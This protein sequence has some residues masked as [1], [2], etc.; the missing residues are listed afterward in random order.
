MVC[1]RAN[2]V[3]RI[4]HLSSKGAQHILSHTSLMQRKMIMLNLFLLCNSCSLPF[5]S[6]PELLLGQKHIVLSYLSNSTLQHASRNSSTLK[7]MTIAHRNIYCHAHS[8]FAVTILGK[9][10]HL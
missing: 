7:I 9:V 2:V 1:L 10:R 3:W 5:Q 6:L 4:L 8:N